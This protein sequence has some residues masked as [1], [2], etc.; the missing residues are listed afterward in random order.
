MTQYEWVFISQSLNKTE[1]N[2]VDKSEPYP[3]I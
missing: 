2:L 1:I 3:Y